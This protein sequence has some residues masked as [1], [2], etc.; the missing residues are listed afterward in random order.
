[1]ITIIPLLLNH[2]QKLVQDYTSAI[3]TLAPSTVAATGV[4][5]YT[6]HI[7]VKQIDGIVSPKIYC[8]NSL[9]S[10]RAFLDPHYDEMVCSDGGSQI[11]KSSF[12][13]YLFR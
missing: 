13:F 11:L 6:L 5:V 4:S 10:E 12:C 2:R 7:L 1:M 8:Q 3:I 9:K